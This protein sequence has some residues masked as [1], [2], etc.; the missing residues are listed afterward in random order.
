MIQA[1]EHGRGLIEDGRQPVVVTANPS[2]L[3]RTPSPCLTR[4]LSDFEVRIVR[5][6]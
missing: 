4:E 1:S 3:V 5:E 2:T 6:Q